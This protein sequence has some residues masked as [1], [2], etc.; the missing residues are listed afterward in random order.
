MRIGTD[1]ATEK[2]WKTFERRVCVALGARRRPSVGSEGWASGSDDDGTAPFSV[3]CKRTTRYSLRRSW[4]EQARAHGKVT[5]RP[6]VLVIA[7]HNDRRPIAVM[8]FAV[9]VELLDQL[10]EE[11]CATSSPLSPEYRSEDSTAA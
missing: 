9:L 1:V 4:I 3:E 6:W 2:A 7:E 8:D 5:K 11:P 10:K